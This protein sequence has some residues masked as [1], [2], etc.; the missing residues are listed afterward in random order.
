MKTA[1]LQFKNNSYV[2]FIRFS[3]V[4]IANT[5]VDIGTYILLTRSITF[6]FDHILIA[7]SI[8]FIAATICSFSFN[9]SWTFNKK[10]KVKIS[11]V[12]RFYSTVG[13]GIFINIGAIYFFHRII[14]IHD[15]ISA[16]L[17]TVFTVL[18]GFTFSK[19]WVF[20]K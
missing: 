13:T 16:I 9:R 14:G 10:D 5:A 18:W 17:A 8:A 2:E 7:K 1:S 11:E 15:I 12:V 6:F 19:F 20:K 4:G 3:I